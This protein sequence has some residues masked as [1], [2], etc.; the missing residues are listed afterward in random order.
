M[1][2]YT[3]AFV[4]TL[5]ASDVD[6]KVSNQHELHGVKKLES[7]FCVIAREDEEKHRFSASLRVGNQG[8]VIPVDITWYNSRAS[9]ASRHEYRLYYSASSQ[10]IM[11]TLNAGDDIFIGKDSLGNIDIIVFPNRASGYSGWVAAPI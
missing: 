4:K 5:T 11:H 6:P 1:K 7:I 9:D 3:Q 10:A 8:T 2:K